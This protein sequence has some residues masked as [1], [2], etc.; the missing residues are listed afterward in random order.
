MKISIA[1]T[2]TKDVEIE[3]NDKFKSLYEENLTRTEDEDLTDELLS[4]CY[5]RLPADANILSIFDA[6]SD[7]PLYEW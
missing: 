1:Y 7:E 2:I 6:E 5:V 4:D 3:V